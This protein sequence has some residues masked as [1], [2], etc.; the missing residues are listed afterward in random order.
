M[1]LR[2]FNVIG[3]AQ[4]VDVVYLFVTIDYYLF[5]VTEIQPQ[6]KIVKEILLLFPQ[7][8]YSCVDFYFI[9][10]LGLVSTAEA[11]EE[12]RRAAANSRAR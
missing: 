4:T 6:T 11:G 10:I 1:L 7:Y 8:C 5:F 3:I 9:F 2:V 12:H